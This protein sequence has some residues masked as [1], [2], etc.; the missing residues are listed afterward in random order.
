VNRAFES[1]TG[2]AGAELSGRSWEELVV[3]DDLGRVRREWSALLAGDE[4]RE[5]D[6]RLVTSDGER[7]LVAWAA[8]AGHDASGQRDHVIV[9]GI[10][11]TDRKRGER[12]LRRRLSRQAEVADLG[13]RGLEGLSLSELT[14]RSVQLVARELGLDH[15]Q[16][17]E[18]T[19]Y[20]GELVLTAA[21]GSRD[22]AVGATG[23]AAEMANQAGF[24]L[25]SEGPVVVEDFAA[26]RRFTP[27]PMLGE[28]ASG[29]SATIPGPRRPYGAICGHTNEHR[30]FSQD[31]VLFVESVA[32]VLAAA[33]ERWRS[34]ESMRHHALHDPL[35][36]LPNRTLFLDR[37]AQLLARRQASSASAAVMFLDVDNFKLVNDSLGHEAGDQLLRAIA[38][39]LAEA[40]RP[41]DTVARFGGDEFVVLCEEVVDGRDAVQVAERLQ[42]SL[43]APFVLDGEQHFLSASIGVAL[44]SGQYA[45]PAEAM[46]DADAAM[47]RAKERGRGEC[48]LFDD[49]MRERALGRLRMETA[50]RG[51]LDREELRVEYQPVVSLGDG[52]IVGLEA[53]MRWDNLGLGPVAP[54]EFIPIAEDTG[55]IVALGR[56]MLETVCRQAVEWG[57][58]LGAAAPVV[59]VN[60]SPRQV[61]NAELIPAVASVLDDTGLDPSRL[62]LEITENVLLSEA[63][64]PW[65]TLHSLKRLGVTL[66]LDDFG[67]GWSSLGYLKRFPVD[68]LKIDRTFVDGLGDEAEDSAIVKA[69]VGM[70]AALELGVI[71]EGVET[72]AQVECLR[73]LGCERAQ[74]YWFGRPRPACDVTPLLLEPGA[75]GPRAPDSPAPLV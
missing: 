47:Y 10:D 22:A 68:V 73:A 39:R 36:G 14:T 75:P 62:G 27:P 53:L 12:E 23:M 70:A 24:T 52:S 17:W 26:E 9:T 4:K 64:S 30:S 55:L 66:M 67:T 38:P 21:V 29:L 58:E 11:I 50:L 49:A 65:N 15:C 48:E 60:L 41:T 37:L 1:L 18:L 33:I 8:V 19:P 25:Q 7:R 44:A 35:T 40:L 45:T 34:D 13:R 54:L 6:C 31:E 28:V 42:E 20:G 51:A 2:H 71:A 46:R 43:A 63:G 3:P 16:V 56:W 57:S 5:F 32:H 59:S 61:A 69:V 74:G 72:A